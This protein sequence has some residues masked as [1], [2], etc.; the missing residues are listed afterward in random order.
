LPYEAH[1]VIVNIS[2][3][4]TTVDLRVLEKDTGTSLTK[5]KRLTWRSTQNGAA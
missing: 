2:R 1:L 5:G 3:F 4:S